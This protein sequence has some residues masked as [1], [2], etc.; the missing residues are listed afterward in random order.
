MRDAFARWNL[1]YPYN[2]I[3]SRNKL[4]SRNSDDLKIFARWVCEMANLVF[5]LRALSLGVV[6]VWWLPGRWRLAAAG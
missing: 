4:K 6:A 1:V 2:I 5:A 3:K